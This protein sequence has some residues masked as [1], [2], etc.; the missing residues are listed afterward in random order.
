MSRV[1]QL[2]DDE[3]REAV[4]SAILFGVTV[5]EFRKIAAQH[6]DAELEEKRRYDAKQ[7]EKK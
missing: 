1:P 3:I 2:V 4:S 6:W 7:W 5:D